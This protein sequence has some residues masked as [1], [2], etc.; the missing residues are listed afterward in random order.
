MVINGFIFKKDVS[1][2][3]KIYLKIYLMYYNSKMFLVISIN[4]LFL[5]NNLNL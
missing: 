5:I 2:K 3:E 1:Y 4:G